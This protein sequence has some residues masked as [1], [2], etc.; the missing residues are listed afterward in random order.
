MECGHDPDRGDDIGLFDGGKVGL[1]V[2]GLD[3][4]TFVGCIGDLLGCNVGLSLLPF[5][6]ANT[7]ETLSTQYSTFISGPLIY[8]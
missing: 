2:I 4:G 8:K 3:D 5:P 6:L 7:T 1:F